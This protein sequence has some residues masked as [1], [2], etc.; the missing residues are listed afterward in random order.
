MMATMTL[1]P[2]ETHLVQIWQQSIN[3]HKPSRPSNMVNTWLLVTKFNIEQLSAPEK[4]QGT[5]LA[6]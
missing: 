5:Y 1:T 3:Y 6:M 4:T 2:D